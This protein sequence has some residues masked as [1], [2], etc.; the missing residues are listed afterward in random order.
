MKPSVAL[1]YDKVNTSYGGAEQVL[2]ALHHAFPTA[3]LYT[4]VYNQ[5]AAPWADDFTVQP[6]FLQSVPGVTTKHQL[7]APLMPLAFESHSLEAFDIVI[8]VSSGEAKGILTKPNQLHISYLLTPPR[9][10]YSHQHEYL[11]TFP[12]FKLPGIKQLSTLL[13]AYLRWW[14]QAAAHRADHIITISELVSQR[15]KK[16]YHRQP[17]AVIYPPVAKKPRAKLG[18]EASNYFLSLSRLV[19][20]KRVD[21]SI[22]ACLQTQQRL[23]VVGSGVATPELQKLAGS[24]AYI[25]QPDESVEHALT[26]AT[27]Q[28][29][30]ILFLGSVSDAEVSALISTAQAL[31]MPGIEDYGITALEAGLQ[32]VPT[33]IAAKSGAAEVLGELAVAVADE[34]VT[35]LVSAIQ[36]LHQKKISATALKKRAQQYQTAAFTSQFQKIVY[37]LFIQHRQKGPHVYL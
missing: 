27:E 21:L 15:V 24:A 18:L 34:S 19:P 10:V 7:L 31:L 33:I 23:V 3:P 37:D 36:Q 30:Q 28:L 1:V 29:K 12:F 20:Y 32:G 22:A 11:K 17:T 2:R 6:S 9:Y 26:T 14:D 5:H 16:Y 35:S 8:S 13:L 25:R 4:S